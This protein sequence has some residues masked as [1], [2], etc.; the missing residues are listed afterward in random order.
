MKERKTASAIGYS[1]NDPGPRLLAAG[2]GAEAAMRAA[3]ADAGIGP[4]DVDYINLHAT[5]TPKNDEMEALALRRAFAGRAPACSGTKAMTGHTLGTAGATEL[6]FC[7]LALRENR[8]PP[9]VW[10]GAADPRLPPLDL[11]A[12]GRR[13]GR[14]HRRACLSNSFAFGGNNACLAIGD[15]R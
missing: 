4:E 6:A 10:D 1:P 2:R 15:P 12:P 13:F 8:L 7:W 5:A 14:A 9:H 11:V 3:L